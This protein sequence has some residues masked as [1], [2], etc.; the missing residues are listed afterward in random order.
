LRVLKASGHALK[1]SLGARIVL[2]H[3]ALI[4]AH[5]APGAFEGGKSVEVDGE[6]FGH[7]QS[8]SW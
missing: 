6:R 4:A 8:P 1:I 3:E 7:E 2:G 5:H